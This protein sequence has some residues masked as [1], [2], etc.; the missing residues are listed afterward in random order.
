L[1][2]TICAPRPARL[3]QPE[4]RIVMHNLIAYL[5]ANPQV[6]VLLIICVVLGLGTFI[7]VLIAL[8]TSGS[9]KTTGEP[10]G[11]ISMLGVLLGR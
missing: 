9:T 1:W 6:L 11:L 10:S 2:A 7:V 4:A 5:R 8:I 3:G